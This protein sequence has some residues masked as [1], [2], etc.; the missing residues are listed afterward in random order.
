MTIASGTRLAG[1]TRLLK[2]SR[3]KRA[4]IPN[5]FG[6]VRETT[7]TMARQLSMTTRTEKRFGRMSQKWLEEHIAEAGK[8]DA[9]R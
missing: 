1:N 4:G 7:T 6:R 9:S 5:W 2:E 8:H 3:T